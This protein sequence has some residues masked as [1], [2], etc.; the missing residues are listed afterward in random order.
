MK[1][2]EKLKSAIKDLGLQELFEIKKIIDDDIQRKENEEYAK[3][4][5]H[6]NDI[7]KI[8]D[9]AYSTNHDP[10][11]FYEDYNHVRHH[12]TIKINNI[13]T[14]YA[15]IKLD[16]TND[17]NL[18]YTLSFEYGHKKNK[19]KFDIESYS[20]DWNGKPTKIKFSKDALVILDVLKIEK[21]PQNEY[22]LG[23]LLNNCLCKVFEL[24][25]QGDTDGFYHIDIEEETNKEENK[26]TVI[27]F[28]DN[29]YSSFPDKNKNEE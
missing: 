7:L 13:V 4:I 5:I 2:L 3:T 6:E 19:K 17:Y 9:F 8:T 24:A 25:E 23:I 12:A 18:N 29:V 10:N 14:L 11:T 15:N 16:R 20:N 26:R 22:L 1:N 28:V 21:T 27:K